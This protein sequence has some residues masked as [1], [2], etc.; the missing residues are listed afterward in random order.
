MLLEFSCNLVCSKL[1]EAKQ[2]KKGQSAK[3]QV[4][5]V[6]VKQGMSEGGCDGGSTGIG[7]E[8]KF[9]DS[10]TA[11]SGAFSGQ[12]VSLIQYV[13]HYLLFPAYRRYRTQYGLRYTSSLLSRRWSTALLVGTL[14]CSGVHVEVRVN[15]RL[16]GSDFC[17]SF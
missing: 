1:V 2:E 12:K 11:H 6:A 13:T 15:G 5:Q 14:T 4:S 17:R 7:D 10:S 3:R 16:R 9:F 8:F